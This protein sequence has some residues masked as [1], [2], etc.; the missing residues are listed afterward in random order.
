MRAWAWWR[1]SQLCFL[2]GDGARGMVSRIYRM[3][4]WWTRQGARCHA[5][6]VPSEKETTTS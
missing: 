3:G 1:L 4:Y 5:R 2:C 6:A